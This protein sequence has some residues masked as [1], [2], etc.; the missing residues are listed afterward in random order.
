MKDEAVKRIAAITGESQDQGV[1]TAVRE[2]LA[3]LE[4]DDLAARLFLT[5]TGI[6]SSAAASTSYLQRPSS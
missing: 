4:K 1:A 6:P 5:A 3:K 2:R